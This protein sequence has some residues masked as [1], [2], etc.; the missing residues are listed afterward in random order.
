MVDEIILR[1]VNRR[2]R[3]MLG[4]K[5]RS[6]MRIGEVLKLTPNDIENRK[7]FIR[8]PKGGKRAEVIFLSHKVSGVEAMRWID[9]IHG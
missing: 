1:T 5:A 3:L 6:G 2:D 7:A 8:E 9:S 4:L